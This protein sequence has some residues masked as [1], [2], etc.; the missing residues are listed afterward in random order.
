MCADR[1]LCYE[2]CLSATYI[3]GPGVYL[4]WYSI[5]LITICSLGRRSKRLALIVGVKEFAEQTSYH[6]RMQLL[7]LLVRTYAPIT[8]AFVGPSYFLTTFNL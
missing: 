5:Q 4:Y 8:E 7:A 2:L 3:Y 1:T 6:I